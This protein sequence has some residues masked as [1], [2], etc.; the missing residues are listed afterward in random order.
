[1]VS[2]AADRRVIDLEYSHDWLANMTSWHDDAEQFYERS[3][4]EIVNGNGVGNSSASPALRPAAL[5]LA[6]NLV[7][8]PAGEGGYVELDYGK[9]G[10]V[11]AM[12]VHGQCDNAGANVCRDPGGTDLNARRSALR[13]GC[14]C[15]VEQHYVYRWDELNRLHEARRYD[16]DDGGTWQMGAR[17]RYR[18]DAA[19]QRVVKQTFDTAGEQRV[20]LYVYPGDFERRGVLV[21]ADGASWQAT[22]GTET[23][24]LIA[25]ARVVWKNRARQSALIDPE[26]RITFAVTN[27]IQ[28]TSAVIELTTGE[29]V[30]VGGFYPNGAREE[31]LGASDEVG[32]AAVPLEPVGFT[33]KEADEEVGLTY[34]GERYLIPR[35]GRWATPDPLSVHAAGGGEVGNSYHYVSGNLLQSRDPL[36]LEGDRSPMAVNPSTADLPADEQAVRIEQMASAQ[37]FSPPATP[38]AK[39]DYVNDL[40]DQPDGTFFDLDRIRNGG[41]LVPYDEDFWKSV[42]AGAQLGVVDRERGDSHLGLTLDARLGDVLSTEVDLSPGLERAG[43]AFAAIGERLE[44]VGLTLTFGAGGSA[45]VFAGADV[46]FGGYLSVGFL[47]TAEVGVYGAAAVTLGTGIGADATVRAGI[48]PDQPST[49]LDGTSRGV[50][51]MAGVG[52]VGGLSYSRSTVTENSRTVPVGYGALQAQSG[53]G[54]V[55][56]IE[57]LPIDVS[58]SWG[59]GAHL[60]LF[61]G[62]E[63]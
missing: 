43:Q 26:Q 38:A 33:G 3:V 21:S 48:S 49:I 8:A 18:Y 13:T 15:D 9:S 17:Q 36:G 29:L 23:Q 7:D 6:S 4:G 41:E 62:K 45:A 19:N 32:G 34:F 57:G 39:G 28:S 59:A 58:T 55:L 24:Y 50:A 61:G 25:G 40:V 44:N 53:L 12:T 42:P 56:P 14:A 63:R 10:N 52:L 35:I 11:L 54:L 47:R 1:M 31:Q 16:R 60:P 30:E 27:L 51:T 20:A 5:Y 22:E 2:S 46:E 37:P